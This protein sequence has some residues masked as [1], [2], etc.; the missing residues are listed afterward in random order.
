M[1]VD[2][3]RRTRHGTQTHGANGAEEEP[4]ARGDTRG[5]VA[6]SF[7]V[8]VFD[9]YFYFPAELVGGFTLSGLVDKPW[10]QVSLRRC[11]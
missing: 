7:F 8:H 4:I 11:E 6:V 9:H 2:V 3:Q 10:S 1:A 5:R